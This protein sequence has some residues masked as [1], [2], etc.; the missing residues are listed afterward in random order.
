MARLI[1]NVVEGLCVGGAMIEIGAHA[2]PEEDFDS[3]FAEQLDLAKASVTSPKWDELRNAVRAA[4][5]TAHFKPTGRSK[6]AQE[7]LLRCLQEPPFPRVNRAVDCLNV[8][9][10]GC[11][12]P[13]S[14]L[15]ADRFPGDVKVRLGQSGESYVFNRAG[16]SIELNGLA[17]VC[18]GAQGDDPLGSPI[19]D[20]MA[21]KIDESTRRM[22]V[23][24]YAPRSHVIQSIADEYAEQLRAN[25]IRWCT[26]NHDASGSS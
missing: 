4:L 5:R 9:S 20:S 16:Q 13:I 2:P 23:V 25:L 6:P 19:K 3:W 24:V 1:Q 8:F 18:G 12:L 22:L 11:G 21:G 17:C 7:Y 15:R 26:A 14:L 10:V